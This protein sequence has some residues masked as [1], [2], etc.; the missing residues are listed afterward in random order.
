MDLPL[1]LA[2]E[3]GVRDVTNYL[4]WKGMI[5]KIYIFDLISKI[6]MEQFRDDRRYADGEFYVAT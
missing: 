6:S 2:E 3:T 4:E 1:A 5:F